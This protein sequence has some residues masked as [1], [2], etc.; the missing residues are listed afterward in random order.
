MGWLAFF[1]CALMAY[2]P[3]I[4]LYG[5]TVAGDAQFVILSLTSAFFWLLS[6]FL[7]GIMWFLITPLQNTHVAT[8]GYSVFWQELFRW[9]YYL[10]YAKAEKGLQTT[11]KDPAFRFNKQMFAF[12]SGLGFG[13]AYGLI[14]YVTLLVHSAG[15]GTLFSQSCPGMSLPFISALSTCL[16]SLL[17]VSW[18]M[19]AFE[20][21]WSRSVVGRYGRIAWVVLSHYGASYAS[22]LN[23]SS[24]ANGCIYSNVILLAL[25]IVC[26]VMAGL[27]IK[28]R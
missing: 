27:S 20:G 9:L 16:T 13:L 8:I 3:I 19:I 25:L 23:S 17:H 26:S 10:M 22:L 14:T 2:G 24:I 1:S 11:A 7:T 6:I 18:M 5:M 4:T 15:P 12:V 28:W 21:Y